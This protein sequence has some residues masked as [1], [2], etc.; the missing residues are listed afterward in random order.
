MLVKIAFGT[1]HGDM[2]RRRNF[3]ANPIKG[4]GPSVNVADMGSLERTMKISTDTTVHLNPPQFVQL[5]PYAQESACQAG[6]RI[7]GALG[8]GR[9]LHPSAPPSAW[10]RLL[11][12]IKR[13]N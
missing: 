1:F 8:E 3:G 7:R 9:I 4:S 2:L 10:A 6:G 5:F 12:A 13:D 11:F